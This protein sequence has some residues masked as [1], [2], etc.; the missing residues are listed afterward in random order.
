MAR[1]Y[2]HCSNSEGV[3]VDQRGTAMGNLVEAHAHAACVVRS[4]IATL[5]SEDWRDWVVHVSDDLND[6][7]FAVSFASLLGKPH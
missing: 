2:F 3:L 6:E 4:L 7:I 5:S 1:L